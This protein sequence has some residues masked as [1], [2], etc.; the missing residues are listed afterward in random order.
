MEKL[1]TFAVPCYNSAEYMDKCINSL[2]KAG[3]L[4]EI[5]IVNDGSTKDNTKE[6]ADGYQSKYPGIIKA[7]HQENGGHGEAV[8]TGLKNATGLYFKVVDSDDWVDEQALEKLLETIRKFTQ[9]YKEFVKEAPDAIVVNYVYEHTLKNTTKIVEYKGQFPENQPFTFEQTKPFPIGKFLAMHALIY[10]TQLLKDINLTLPKH[11]FYVD[12]VFVYTP[13]PLVKNFYYL[14][15]DFYRYFIG[16][17]DQSVNEQIIMKR[18]DQ[19]VKVTEIL[20]A[21]H[22][23]IKIKEKS[24]KLYKYML[25]F[26][27]IMMTINSIY[28]IKIGTKESMK[29]KKELWLKLKKDNVVVYKYCKRKFV[30]MA[31]SNCPFVCWICKGIYNIAR[32]VFKFN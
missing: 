8:N 31:S 5:I 10:K 6:I 21:S 15:V 30:G 27:S 4:A 24:K 14:N 11:T 7:V 9:E 12:N 22:D 26:L 32:K 16:R 3:D 20:I 19:H 28:L 1:I 18:I 17:E 29:I 25:S 13:M 2:L 23:V